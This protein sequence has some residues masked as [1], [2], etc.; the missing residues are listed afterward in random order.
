MD[1]YNNVPIPQPFPVTIERPKLSNQEFFLWF[2]III[3]LYSTVSAFLNMIFRVLNKALPDALDGIS[4]YSSYNS[5]SNGLTSLSTPLSIIIISFPIF[6]LLTY[7]TN[8]QLKKNP[9]RASLRFRK[10]VIYLTIFLA[11]IM[12]VTD[13]IVLLQYFLRGEIT[14]RFIVKVLCILL[15]SGV[16]GGYYVTD[17]RRNVAEKSNTIKI[18][19]VASFLIVI[20]AIVCT[21][22]VFGSPQNTRK[23]QFDEQRVTILDNMNRDVL[24][25]WQTHGF[26]PKNIND[27]ITANQYYSQTNRYLDPDI[28]SNNKIEYIYLVDTSYKICATFSTDNTSSNITP[29]YNSMIS[30]SG[31]INH[32]SGYTCFDKKIDP[33]QFPPNSKN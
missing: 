31:F 30:D 27:L 4:Y 16:V 11:C 10:F 33:V 25:Y 26:I 6:I 23:L 2:G 13:L 9:E 19:A 22:F 17:L 14:T 24:D 5:S 32:K 7:Y 1:N 20:S 15:V 18:F 3:T 28:T 21:F 29:N 12:V 8:K